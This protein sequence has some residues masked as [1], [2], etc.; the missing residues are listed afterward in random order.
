MRIFYVSAANNE[1]SHLLNLNQQN[2]L[3]FERSYEF[4]V[5]FDDIMMLLFSDQRC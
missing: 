4:L 3:I 2:N 5:N 1:H